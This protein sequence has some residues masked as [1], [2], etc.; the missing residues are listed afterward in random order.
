MNKNRLNLLRDRKKMSTV[1]Q[2]GVLLLFVGAVQCED[3]P[4]GIRG[5]EVK[6][7][8]RNLQKADDAEALCDAC[9][10]NVD[11]VYKMIGNE[12]SKFTFVQTKLR[13]KLVRAIGAHIQPLKVCRDLKMC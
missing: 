8:E 7:Y 12:L 3:R 9:K 2:L 4:F 13:E 11:Y 6:S 1:F 10:K 5:L